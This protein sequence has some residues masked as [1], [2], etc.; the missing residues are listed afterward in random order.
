MDLLIKLAER[1]RIPNRAMRAG[2][3]RLLRQRLEAEGSGDCEDQLERRLRFIEEMRAG[4]IAIS[5]EQANEQH[6]ELPA[7]FFQTVL[8]PHL[9]YSAGWWPSGVETLTQSEEA[10]LRLT[11][12]RGELENGHRVLD[13]GCGWGS[14]ALWVARHYPR[15]HVLAVSGSRTQA[16][17]IRSRCADLCVTNVEVLTTDVSD[18]D[19]DARFDRVVSVEMFEHLRNWPEMYRRVASWLRPDGKM[20]LH[21]FCHRRHAYPYVDQG[22]GDWM[23]RHFFTGGMMPSD[24]LPYVFQDDL[25]VEGHWRVNGGHYSRT[26]EAWL[27]QMDRWRNQLSPVLREVYGDGSE[28]WLQRWR[29]FFMAC[30]ELFAF[31]GGNEWWVSH[32]R[33]VPTGSSRRRGES[34]ATASRPSRQ[35]GHAALGSAQE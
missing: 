28:Q 6:Y 24:D 25:S 29:L 16:E 1:G 11:C 27:D 19:L 5:C 14:L 3:R 12:Q 8:G 33:L 10:M 4:P 26:L 7:P 35:T 31:R 21:V 17:H 2:I 13:L 34:Q 9:K 23:A 22:P 32:Y 30:S 18:L 15:S 20:L